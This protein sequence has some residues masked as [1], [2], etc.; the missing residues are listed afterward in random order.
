M[1]NQLIGINNNI[2]VKFKKWSKID[3]YASC[4]G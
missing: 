4:Y 3:I 1:K 2:D